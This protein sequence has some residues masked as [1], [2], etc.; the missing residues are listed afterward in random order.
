MHLLPVREDDSQFEVGGGGEKKKRKEEKEEKGK[1]GGK[2]K[3]KKRV[4]GISKK[5]E[6]I[7][8]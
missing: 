2:K 6:K 4:E 3:N 7:K 1:E 8:V 5:D